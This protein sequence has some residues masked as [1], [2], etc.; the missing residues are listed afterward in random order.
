MGIVNPSVHAVAGWTAFLVGVAGLPVL[1]LQAVDLEAKSGATSYLEH[2]DERYASIALSGS[3]GLLLSCLLLVHLS[4]LRAI[5]TRDR[6]L[7]QDAAAGVG[8]L[9]A[10][11][12]AVGSASAILA[13]YGAHEGFPYEAVRPMGML[14]ENLAPVL[15]PALAGPAV[16]VAALGLRDGQLPHWLGWAGAVFALVLAAFGVVLPGAGAL[17]ALLWLTV[18][19]AGMLLT[20]RATARQVA[21]PG[22]DAVR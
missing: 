16:L 18:M 7:L 15:L 12:I 22:A 2:V 21:G 1:H 20:R 13:A 10:V 9:A 14:A 17:P 3:G 19:G 11:G 6:G 8:T 5:G 4:A